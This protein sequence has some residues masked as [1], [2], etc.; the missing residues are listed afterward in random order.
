LARWP[1]FRRAMAAPVPPATLDAVSG[2]PR[3]RPFRAARE[4]IDVA[5][6]EALLVRGEKRRKRKRRKSKI[7][8]CG[9]RLEH[10]MC[11]YDNGKLRTEILPATEDQC[12]QQ[13][14]DLHELNHLRSE[15]V[16]KLT[17]ET[18]GIRQ[19]IALPEDLLAIDNGSPCPEPVVQTAGINGGGPD[20]SKRM[21][22]TIR[23]CWKSIEATQKEMDEHRKELEQM[24]SRASEAQSEA[25]LQRAKLNVHRET[26]EL[27]LREFRQRLPPWPPAGSSEAQPEMQLE[28]QR[29]LEADSRTTLAAHEL[30]AQQA[31]TL[32]ESEKRAHEEEYD[33][34]KQDLRALR[35]SEDGRARLQLADANAPLLRQHCA[36]LHG[37]LDALL[38]ALEQPPLQPAPAAT[39][40]GFERW[41]GCLAGRL[42]ELTAR[43][44]ARRADGH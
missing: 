37:P 42:G 17:L 40:D 14:Q 33:L 1:R 39:A 44:A 15:E 10:L 2:G 13:E 30:G 32:L 41:V 7:A 27:E 8:I 9:A 5:T 21:L 38:R 24:R 26:R 19:Q 31:R 25:A 22:A 43:L 36:A 3:E 18:Q 34:L 23:R 11:F 28:Q 29:R 35:A 12:K 4:L 16:L 6:S 20:A